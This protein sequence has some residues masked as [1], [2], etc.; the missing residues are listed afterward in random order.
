MRLKK[1]LNDNC[2]EVA[3]IGVFGRGYF[4]GI[5]EGSGQG[6]DPDDLF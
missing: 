1:T 3:K 2:S 5:W 4:G 6:F